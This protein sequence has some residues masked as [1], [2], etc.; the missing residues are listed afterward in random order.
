MAA[1]GA[2]RIDHAMALMRLWWCLPAEGGA[3][4]GGL[5]VYYPLEELL[6]L[7]R[8]ESQRNRCL[9]VGEDLGVVP[10]E[11]RQQLQDSHIYGNRVLYFDTHPDGR[12]RLPWEQTPDTL[13]MVTNHDVPTLSDWWQGSDLLRRR[14]LGLLD[15]PAELA[16]A[17]Q[18]RCEDKARLL[19]WL[20]ESGVLSAEGPAPDVAQGFDLTLCRA[21]HRACARGA[22]RLLL[23]QLEDLQLLCEPVNIPG[24]YREYPNW[25]RKQ[26]RATSDLLHDPQVRDLL[27]EVN[28]ER[29][30]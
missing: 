7:L 16:H 14:D 8:L 24:T 11:F 10:A 28:R 23:L 20:A 22:S 3:S 30:S 19:D 5:Y 9:V 13:T 25:R 18:Q 2:L 27:A 29:Q 21:V 12:Q 15:D 1:A 17:Q 26:A 6:A 4:C